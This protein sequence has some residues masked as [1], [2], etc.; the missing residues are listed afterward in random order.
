MNWLQT[1]IHTHI[2]PAFDD[3]A[4]DLETAWELLRVQKKSGVNRVALTPHFYP[5]HEALDVFVAR[6]QQAYNALMS[7][8]DAETMPQLLL[9]AEVKYTPQLTTMDLHQLTIGNGD[10][11]LLELSDIHVPA[12][13]KPVVETMQEQGIT[14]VLAHIERCTYFRAEPFRLEKLIQMGT[15]AQ[16]DAA[17]LRNR[18]TK[19]FATAC[20]RNGLAHILA[21]DAHNLTDRA[22][23]L[24]ELATARN[25]ELLRWVERF[26][27]SVWENTP[28]PAFGIHP[29]KKKL[30]GYY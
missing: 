28:P 26:A 7:G 16:I 8:Y 20:F 19:A 18:Q 6:R 23:C 24:A 9:G 12:H 2:L 10:Y 1:D 13:I 22:P 30:F 5:M 25:A 14:P 4:K 15:L 29:L 21:S 27:E 11:L 3:G 17:S